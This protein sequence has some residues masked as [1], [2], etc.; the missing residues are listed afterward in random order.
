MTRYFYD[1]QREMLLAFDPDSNVIRE[2]TCV[3]AE[4]SQEASANPSKDARLFPT[5]RNKSEA[6]P[7]KVKGKK[8]CSICGTPGHNAKTCPSATG[9]NVR[10]DGMPSG[11]EGA[12]KAKKI[13][14]ML[15]E[16]F[17]YPKIA[18]DCQTTTQVVSFIA[19]QM[20]S[21]GEL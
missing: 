21:R 8:T 2:L 6:R 15:S 7:P 4:T 12:D 17:P 3:A 13:K 14:R 1:E 9:E 19:K 5:R 11:A 10:P 18:R 16:H 20:Q